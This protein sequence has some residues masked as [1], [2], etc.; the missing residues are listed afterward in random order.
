[1]APIPAYFQHFAPQERRSRPELGGRHGQQ[2][3][4]VYNSDRLPTPETKSQLNQM[5]RI[6]RQGRI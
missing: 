1:V 5:V 6:V 4:R 2:L 3:K